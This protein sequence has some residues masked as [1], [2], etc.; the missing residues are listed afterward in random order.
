MR[1]LKSKYVYRKIIQKVNR[2][3][4]SLYKGIVYNGSEDY[5]GILWKASHNV[6][7]T[8]LP[9]VKNSEEAISLFND[10]LNEHFG[11]NIKSTG[12]IYFVK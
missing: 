7:A 4:I 2:K 8:D 11:I 1:Y 10:I 3:D 6:F 9:R 12:K 5:F